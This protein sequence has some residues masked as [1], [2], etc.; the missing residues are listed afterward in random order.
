MGAT[1]TTPNVRNNNNNQATIECDHRVNM[2]ALTAE[3]ST[4]ST[5]Y[6]SPGCSGNY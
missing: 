4:P 3:L 6:A 1:P 2:T 5:V